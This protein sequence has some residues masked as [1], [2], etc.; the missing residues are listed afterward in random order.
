MGATWKA[1]ALLAVIALQLMV[2]YPYISGPVNGALSKIANSFN[3][4][5]DSP[6]MPSTSNSTFMST[7][8]TE[9]GEVLEYRA[10][11]IVMRDRLK[12]LLEAGMVPKDIVDEVSTYIGS[13]TDDAINSMD[14]YTLKQTKERLEYYLKLSG[15]YEMSSEYHPS[16]VYKLR[17]EI[18]ELLAK[19]SKYRLKAEIYGVDNILPILD[20]AEQL[21]Q[22]ALNTLNGN[23][24]DPETIQL[25]WQKVYNAKYLLESIEHQIDD[26]YEE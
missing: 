1:M 19:V 14:Y 15:G 3:I 24:S 4:F 9:S 5:D 2:I 21:L 26:L 22:D 23:P 17:H 8:T 6:D 25:A 20:Q 12:A 10:K 13:L 11:V 18:N 7:S 16:N